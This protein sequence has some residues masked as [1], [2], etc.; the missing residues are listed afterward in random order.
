VGTKKRNLYN[1][2]RLRSV[3]DVKA[4]YIMRWVDPENN[5]I[6]NKGPYSSESKAIAEQ[7]A[8]LL[9]GICSWLVVYNGK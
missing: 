8:K 5:E 1:K 3:G 6:I 4:A 7:N 2:Q 9:K